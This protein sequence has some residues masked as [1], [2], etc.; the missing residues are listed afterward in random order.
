MYP[1]AVATPVKKQEMTITPFLRS[2]IIQLTSTWV[3]VY[4]GKKFGCKQGMIKSMKPMLKRILPKTLI[5]PLLP[6]F[7]LLQA[8]AANMRY[9]FPARGLNVAVIT[10][11]NGKTTTAA[12][13]GK[14]FEANGWSVGINSTAF[15]QIGKKYEL[16]DTNMTVTDPFRLFKM[17]KDMREAKVD[18]VILE[19]TSHALVQNRVL[20]I[21]F[22]VAAITN[23][24]QDHLDYHGSM[25]NYA[26]AKGKLFQK[27]ADFHVLNR[28][29]EW[30]RFFDQ[31]SPAQRK[32]TYGVDPDAEV[33]ITEAK[34]GP[35]GSKLSIKLERALIQPNIKLVG[36]FNAYNALT[37][38]TMAHALGIEPEIIEE[39]LQNLKA[40]PG[41]MEQVVS[42]K[43]FKILV[44]YAHTPDAL[45]NVLE[46]LRG[47]TRGRIITVFGAT[48]DR[49]KSKRPLMGKV[50]AKLSD[51]VVLTDDDPYTE[52]PIAI[53]AEVM[54][55]MKGVVDGAELYEVGDRRGAIAK[56][57]ELAKRGDT[58]LLAGIGH[59]SYRV[60]DGKKLKWSEREVAEE[61]LAKR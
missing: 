39:G 32:L 13:L 36:K 25:D 1:R 14:I 22:K 51:L 21:P 11:T 58:I 6:I 40:V 16:N 41:R 48:G 37:A 18:W 8:F 30:F 57:I 50:V 27:G 56:A 35:D 9:G 46:T 42:K 61:L 31:F 53:R 29:D 60:I 20:G 34:L 55:G 12:F 49:D 47:I 26:A 38:A 4:T 10:G 23:L 17:L 59:Q 15:Y 28:D 33:R 54:A 7:H 3:K 44:D 5:T 2:M 43:G 45:A 52:N 19:T 24:T